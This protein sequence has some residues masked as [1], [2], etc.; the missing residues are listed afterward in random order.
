MIV[1]NQ[2]R[3]WNTDLAALR[4]GRVVRRHVALQGIRR[5]EVGRVA[6]GGVR[7]VG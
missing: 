5:V 4:A 3:L 1:I 2:R 6:D 7:E